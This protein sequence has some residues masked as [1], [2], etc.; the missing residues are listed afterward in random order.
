MK[1][2]QLEACKVLADFIGE[3]G[4]NTPVKPYLMIETLRGRNDPN[5]NQR[6][7]FKI[8]IE[9]DK[10]LIDITKMCADAGGFHY[11]TNGCAIVHGCGMDMGFYLVDRVRY[12]LCSAGFENIFGETYA[13][14]L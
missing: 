4:L 5:G 11:S 13:G 8:Y 6:R 1:E 7:Y 9:K 12:S 3:L 10:T 14:L 2:K